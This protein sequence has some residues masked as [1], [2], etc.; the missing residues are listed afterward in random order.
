[1]YL[2]HLYGRT[3]TS[4]FNIT[5]PFF[6]E[7]R[8]KE[9]HKDEI[10]QT[11]Q[12]AAIPVLAC[13]EAIVSNKAEHNASGVKSIS[14]IGTVC[15]NFHLCKVGFR[16]YHFNLSIKHAHSLYTT[17]TNTKTKVRRVITLVSHKIFQSVGRVCIK[18]IL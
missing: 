13:R 14:I 9:N 3:K 5:V 2:I 7:I 18:S 1:M 8:F 16:C 15:M 10:T 11:M 6:L 17:Y 12:A 4:I